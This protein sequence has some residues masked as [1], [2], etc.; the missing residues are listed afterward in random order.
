MN[1]NESYVI[2]YLRAEHNG[3]I[4]YQR[5]GFYIALGDDKFRVSIVRGP[6]K[7]YEF[8]LLEDGRYDK[9]F[10]DCDLSRGLYIIFQYSKFKTNG[11]LP[12]SEGWE[13]FKTQITNFYKKGE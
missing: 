11:I 4:S 2:R 7:L 8:Y 6:R 12:T 9:K 3:I 10:S 1:I 13:D 5:D